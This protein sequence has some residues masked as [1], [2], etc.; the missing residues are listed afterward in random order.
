MGVGIPKPGRKPFDPNKTGMLG[1]PVET[2]YL[3]GVSGGNGADTQLKRDA[4]PS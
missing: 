4:G 3:D 1:H 2:F